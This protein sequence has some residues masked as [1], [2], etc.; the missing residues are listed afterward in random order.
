MFRQPSWQESGERA[1]EPIS[2]LGAVSGS[3]ET[4]SGDY[5]PRPGHS[6]ICFVKVGVQAEAEATAFQVPT[7]L[8]R[9]T[10]IERQMPEL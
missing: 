1:Q 9:M 6:V 2:P 8:G 10:E 5:G 3:E 7:E 4:K